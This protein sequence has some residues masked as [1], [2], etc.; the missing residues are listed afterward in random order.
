MLSY[1]YENALRVGEVSFED[2]NGVDFTSAYSRLMEKLDNGVVGFRDVI[3]NENLDEY[4]FFNGYKNVVVVGMGGSILGTMAI[5]YAVSAFKNN[6]YFIDNSDPE[7]TLSILNKIDLNDSII[8]IVSKSGNTLETL[9]NYYLIKKKIGK[10]NSFKGK[11]VFITNDGKL[12][13]EAEKNN[14]EILS[15]PENVPGRFSVFTA[16]GLAPLYSLGTDISKILK[17]ARE[18]DK[19]CR[20]EDILK[21]PALLNGVIHYLYDKKGRDISVIMSYIESL[22]YFGEWCKQLIGESLGKRGE[23]ITPLLSIGAKDQHS[24]LQLYMDGKKDKIITFIVPK[25][26]RLDEEIVFEDIDDKE[27]CC[28]LSD[29]IK[30]EQEATEIAL[31]NNGI[32]NVKITIDEVNEEA[33]GALMYM[34]EMQ[35][36]FMGELYNLNTYNQPAVEGEKKICW[37]LIKKCDRYGSK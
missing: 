31:T 9:V 12:K 11:I 1:D 28:M 7:K 24:L 2:I 10:L 34:Y 21:N 36:G 4:K 16:V 37:E 20:N 5:Y 33:L 8:Y 13:R 6:A 17:G 14:Y 29:I 3:Y 15:I 18:M 19:L 32:P 30:C 25:K 26:Y 22:R 23:G 35:V 27:V